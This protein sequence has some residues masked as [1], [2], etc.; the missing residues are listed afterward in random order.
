LFSSTQKRNTEENECAVDVS[1]QTKAVLGFEDIRHAVADRCQTEM[2]KA[3]AQVRPFLESAPEIEASLAN[4]EEV[5][6]LL[7]EPLSLPLSDLS[8]VRKSL[9][10]A[11]KGAM[12][13]PQALMAICR[14]LFAFEHTR[15]LLDARQ[16]RFPRLCAMAQDLPL[17]HTLASRLDRSFEASGEISDRA[18]EALK[19]ARDVA[20][21]AHQRIRNRLDS[22]LRDEGFASKLQ[23]NYY[24]V[25][26]DRYVVPV[27]AAHQRE[28]D[29]IVHNSSQTG[30]TLFVEPQ[31]MV[32][33]GNELAIANAAVLEEERKVL[34]EL[35]RTVARHH[36]EVT[37]GVEAAA[38]LDE[39][40]SIGRLSQR[41]KA[42]TPQL[43]AP[44]G[45]LNLKQ[46]RHPRLLLKG[47]PVVANDVCFESEAR[48]LVIS[49]PN[50]GGKTITLTGVGLCALMVRAGLPIPVEEGSQI[51]LFSSA[52]SAI[53]DLQ[54]LNLG[55]STFSAHVTALKGILDTAKRGALVLVDEIAADTD[56]REGAAI[57][58][59][60]LEALIEHGAVVLATTHLEEL[61]ALAHV[62]SRFINARVGF[63]SQRMLPTYRLQMGASGASSAIEVA[64]RVGLSESVCT[65]AHALA[66]NAG[67]ALSKAIRATEVEREQYLKLKDQAQLDTAEA[68]RLKQLLDT[69][70]STHR[71]QRT[72]AEL[73]FRESLQAELEFARAQLRQ[74]VS[75]LEAA[76]SDKA[77]SAAKQAAAELTQ[78]INE[79]TVA[80]RAARQSLDATSNTVRQ[81]LDIRVGARARLDSLDATVEIISVEG[82]SVTVLAGALK[83]KVSASDLSGA[84]IAEPAPKRK[85]FKQAVSPSGPAVVISALAAPSLDVRGERA[86]D[87]LRHIEQF[88]DRLTREG[89]PAALVVHGHGT[90]ALKATVRGFLKTSPYAKHFRP[91]DNA[92]GGDGVTVVSL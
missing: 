47:D 3:R 31:A 15:E 18:S 72:Q 59:A 80:E 91:G 8:D 77:L 62:D 87:A 28:I 22:M 90:G 89:E 9:F 64:R 30:Q 12:L 25:R 81:P 67:G 56:P 45:R 55:L 1:E 27:M 39:L 19:E 26:N 23:E 14:C 58:T 24:S 13:E 32:G 41:I 54:D 29:G 49:G 21:R 16:A 78:R 74:L 86:D 68:A 60:V 76:K 85:T 75:T 34:I 44:D 35:S 69:E 43:L 38:A 70:L 84:T 66:T 10:D 5:R 57:A 50:A 63:D 52:H 48:V 73:K 7:D 42:V 88:L 17:L 61:K 11:T 82:D 40:E 79:Q 46:L 92:E 65:R 20:R 2:G 53:G 6:R 37:A 4:V 71:K 83:M 33:L 51:P 36:Q